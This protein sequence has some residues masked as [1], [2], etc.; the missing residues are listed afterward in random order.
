MDAEPRWRTRQDTDAP[1]WERAPGRPMLAAMGMRS[2]DHPPLPGAGLPLTLGRR[3][4]AGRGRP[5][6]P[7]A[8]ARVR[9]RARERPD[10]ARRARRAA[11]PRERLRARGRD[12]G[13]GRARAGRAVRGAARAAAAAGR[14]RGRA[15]PRTSPEE[16]GGL[17]LDM[18]EQSVVFEAAGYSLL[19]PLALNCAAPDEGNMHL[20]ERDRDRR[21]EGALPAA[22]RRR[23]DPLVLRDDRARARRRVGSRR[24]ADDGDEGRRRLADRRPQVADHRRRGRRRSRS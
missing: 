5:G 12:P 16:Y 24:A 23:R 4:A 1:A 19:G 2:Q 13:G 21:A 15:S 11:R 6:R 22:A 10:A 17:G 9:R 8:A 3:F 20:L 18:F 7:V 14:R